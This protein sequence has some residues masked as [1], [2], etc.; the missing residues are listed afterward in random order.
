MTFCEKCLITINTDSI[1]YIKFKKNVGIPTSFE[2]SSFLKIFIIIKYEVLN[3]RK[4]LF[5]L[6][7][8]GHIVTRIVSRSPGSSIYFSESF[9]V[10]YYKNNIYILTVFISMK[11]F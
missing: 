11:I 2:T 3:E 10:Q 9:K 7:P 5:L 1:R 6:W 4:K 8:M